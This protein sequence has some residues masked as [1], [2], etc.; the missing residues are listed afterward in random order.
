MLVTERK[1][2]GG[3]LHLLRIFWVLAVLFAAFVLISGFPKFAASLYHPCLDISGM[4][5]NK[6]QI[7]SDQ[8]QALAKYGISIQGYALY[9]LCC[10]IIVTLLLIG[11]GVLIFLRKSTERMS[12]FVSLVLIMFGAFGMGEVHT[13]QDLPYTIELVITLF[14][15]LKWPALGILFCTFPDG[16][17]VPRWSWMLS[18]LFI[19]QQCM[20]L[21]LPY[22][23]NIDNWPPPLGGLGMLVLY[24]SVASTQVYRYFAVASSRQRQQ[25]KWLAFSFCTILFFIIAIR[26]LPVM[27]SSLNQPDSFYQLLGPGLRMIGYLCLP[28]GIGIALLRHRLWDI[29]IVINRTLVYIVFS[30]CILG[31]YVLV[32]F[33]ASAL[34]RGKYDL[35]FSLLATA[36]IAITI[37]PL[38]QRVQQ[39]VNRMMFGDRI[40]PYRALSN[41]GQRLEESLPADAL[42]P[43]IVT[44]VAQALRLPYVAI[45]WD[46]QQTLT[47]AGNTQT[48]V[49]YGIS[50]QDGSD[51]RLPLVHQGE[52]VG[53]LILSPRQR[54][55]ELTAADL[56]LIRDLAPQIG[57]AVHS[58]RLT[59]DLQRLMTD[60]QRSRERLVTTREEERRRLRRD[61]HDSLGPVLSSQILTLSAIKKQLRQDPDT[62]E[63]L[64]TEAITHAQNGIADIRRLVYA[65]RPPALDD[66]GLLSALRKQISQ[67]HASGIIMEI[68]APEALPPLPA[69]IEIACY[70][71]VQE[72]LTNIVHHAR[73][74]YAKV[75]LHM[76]EDLTVEVIDNGQGLPPDV[77]GGVGLTSM[78]ER[79]EELGG[80]CRIENAPSMGV[81]VIAHL[82]L[83]PTR[84]EEA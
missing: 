84:Y 2:E 5:C 61:L 78:R 76:Q 38:R 18:I 56:R 19:I 77:R 74:T 43:T 24:G 67:Y 16:R 62:A 66:L 31:L 26:S 49:S 45:V 70:R 32:V 33:G 9:A 7:R 14:I 34:F 10:D 13:I 71:I 82:P 11:T 73:A 40:D 30:F 36:L 64:L 50:R 23:Y 21:F 39:S 6:F 8:L 44:S 57:I 59:A 55:E 41:L 75:R 29:D 52:R 51:L 80:T 58:A 22:P 37:Q 68:E 1:L 72:A 48:A 60:L 81:R 27:F 54:G 65:L 12:L 63:E 25:I 69:A 83:F 4:S 42:L 28:F 79:A 46:P 47:G 53:D 15:M 20:F 17:L 35:L 3:T